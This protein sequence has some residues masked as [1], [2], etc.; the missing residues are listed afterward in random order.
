MLRVKEHQ[1]T[2]CMIGYGL[3]NF[4]RCQP[5]PENC[6]YCYYDHT[7]C[8]SCSNNMIINSET[9]KCDNPP[10]K[11]CMSISYQEKDSEKNCTHCAGGY[12]L[13]EENGKDVC[14]PC[15]KLDSNCTYC[16]STRNQ[17]AAN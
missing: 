16:R 8:L 13:S 7:R 4:K 17:T 12:Y 5:C 10:I 1:C 6:E 2:Q 14:S 11:N 3:D 15:S 9:G